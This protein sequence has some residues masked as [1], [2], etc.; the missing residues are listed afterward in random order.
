[1][2]TV[3]VVT[4]RQSSVRMLLSPRPCS[5]S[6]WLLIMVSSAPANSKLR[7]A[8]RERLGV[9]PG[10]KLVFLVARSEDQQVQAGLQ[11]EHAEHGDIVQVSHDT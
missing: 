2:R 1:M 6:D 10:V 11:S 4:P 5:P 8:W 3:S 9:R 7:V